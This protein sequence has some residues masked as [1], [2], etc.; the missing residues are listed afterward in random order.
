[1][2][3]ILGTVGFAIYA[4]SSGFIV[5]LIAEVIL[6]IGQSFISGADSALMYDSLKADHRENEYVKYEGRNF[7]GR[8]KKEWVRQHDRFDGL[9]PY[10]NSCGRKHGKIIFKRNIMWDTVS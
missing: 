6:G 9:F 10:T 8:W 1:M 2:G 3:S 4:V 7:S 5:F